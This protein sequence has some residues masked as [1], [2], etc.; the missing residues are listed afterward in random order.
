[1]S[2]LDYFRNHYAMLHIK[3]LKD[4]DAGNDQTETRRRLRMC[5]LELAVLENEEHAT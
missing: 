1:M 3:L 2:E 5:E 4:I